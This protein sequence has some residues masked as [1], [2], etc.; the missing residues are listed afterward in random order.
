M[1]FIYN[2]RVRDF[3]PHQ[4]LLINLMLKSGYSRIL[5]ALL[6][7]LIFYSA[8]CKTMSPF[9][10]SQED[11]DLSIKAYNFEFESKAIEASA[12][13]VHPDHRP[14]YLAQS[15]DIAKRI[16]IFEATILDIKL[17]NNGVRISSGSNESIDQ[18]IVVIRYQAAILPS[19]K[20]ESII[21]EQEWVRYQ[22]QWVTIPDLTRF[23]ER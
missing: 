13:F 16:S 20:L 12:R 18:A 9:Y 5:T 14:K 8:S 3:R 11:L 10:Q 2:Q 15:L 22:E 4:L 7:I 19:T 6:L 21:I 17:F 23:L 1:V